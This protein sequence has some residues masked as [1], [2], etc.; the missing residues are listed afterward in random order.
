M[1]V[2][3]YGAGFTNKGAQLMLYATA[4]RLRA[5]DPAVRC[6]VERRGTYEERAAYRLRTILPGFTP[7]GAPLRRRVANRFADFAVGCVPASLRDGYGIVRPGEPDALIDVSGYGYGDKWDLRVFDRFLRRS[8]E[9]RR[10]GRRVILLPQ[11]FGPF[12]KPGYAERFRDVVA[13]AD[14]VYARDP[15]SLEHVRRAAPGADHVRL[16]PDITIFTPGAAPPGSASARP[17]V[18][19]VPNVRMTDQ[20]KDD[21]GDAYFAVL[22]DAARRVLAAGCDVQ[23]SLHEM[24]DGDLD[25]GRRLVEAVGLG[26]CTLCLDTDPL[27]IKGRIANARFLVSSRF[28]SIVG[29]LSSGVPAITLGWAHKYETIL[30]DFGVPELLCDAAS[31]PRRVPEL[32]DQLNAAERRDAMRATL[33]AAK[34]RMR[35]ANAAMWDD[36]YGLLGLRGAGTSERAPPATGARGDPHR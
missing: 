3:I 21:W 34:E 28:H 31:A 12:E 20:G 17:Y 15:I 2:E 26:R 18:C 22:T 4:E 7:P 35:P 23:V 8:A 27:A 32:V 1:L 5:A 10:A 14:R 16:A 36:V 30:Q 9:Y 24:S 25:L 19:F 33:A 13:Q 6:C 29:A 11:M